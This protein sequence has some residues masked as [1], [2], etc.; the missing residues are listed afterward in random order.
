MTV[1]TV[2]QDALASSSQTDCVRP[3]VNSFDVFDT[4]IARRCFEPLRIHEQVERA[5]GVAGFALMRRAA[6]VSIGSRAYNYNIDDI[7]D[8]LERTHALGSEV[9]ESLKR[10]E[11]DA[12]INNAI[13]IADNI[14]LVRDGDILVSDMYLSKDVIHSLLCKAGLDKNVGLYVS[15]CDKNMGA[16]WPKLLQKF[17][18]AEHFGDNEHGDVKVPQAHGVNAKHSDVSK[19][20]QCEA[21]L[22]KIGLRDVALLCREVRLSAS[23]PNQVAGELRNLQ[24]SLNFPLL[25]L[26]CVK[27]ARLVRNKKLT[28]VLFGSRDGLLWMKLFRKF[29]DIIGLDCEVEYF[30]TSRLARRFPS[31]DYL[32]Y[33]RD[34]LV[35]RTLFIDLNGS[36]WSIAHLAAKLGLERCQ[37]FILVK[38]PI[39]AAYVKSSGPTPDLCDFCTVIDHNK[40][41]VSGCNLESLNTAP[42]GSIIDVKLIDGVA[43]PVIDHDRRSASV[44]ELVRYQNEIF[45]LLIAAIDR[46]EV[47][48]LMLLDDGT[49][50]EIC[51][52]LA[53][54]INVQPL[55]QTIFFS[56]AQ[57]ENADVCA[58][59]GCTG[60][61][62]SV[63]Q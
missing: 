11:I 61:Y 55:L 13:P 32:E 21:W 52:I 48:N 43:V 7:Y 63:N 25:L 10:A 15:A 8:E 17:R 12:E 41:P 49:V 19:P 35:G 23:S 59:L 3:L 38:N 2:S 18:I 46:H 16:A 31:S 44:I 47:A 57:E 36:G 20:N 50:E 14:A 45:D 34:R 37:V 29:A 28:R 54:Q 40:D 39:H 1:L 22:M 51:A 62:S 30:Y 42:Y 4:L 24:T 5:T 56:A 27:L 26:A 53:H 9:L 33:A 58:R 60:V 6:E